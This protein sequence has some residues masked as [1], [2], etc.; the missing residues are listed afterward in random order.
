MAS[1][2]SY[3][4]WRA[5]TPIG[6]SWLQFAPDDLRAAYTKAQNPNQWNLQSDEDG[7]LNRGLHVISQ[8]GSFKQ[9]EAKLESELKAA[10]ETGI[11]NGDYVAFGYRVAPS[12]DSKPVRIDIDNSLSIE[13]DWRLNELSTHGRTYDRTCVLPLSELERI[14]GENSARP[15]SNA[16]ERIRTAIVELQS[17]GGGFENLTRD[18]QAHAVCNHL[19]IKHVPFDGYSDK[20]I[21]KHLLAICGPKRK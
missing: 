11:M 16:I 15:A 10:I 17:G 12:R 3:S 9:Q 20:N 14:V 7:F 2:V 6:D 4:L 19:G 5:A 21:K 8:I 18:L 1:K 13:I